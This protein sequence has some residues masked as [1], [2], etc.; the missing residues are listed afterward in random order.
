M[1]VGTTRKTV[2][3]T[4]PFL[5][6]GIAEVQEAGSYIVETSEELLQD[7]SFPA[8]QRIATLIFLPARPSGAS[9]DRVVRIDL[10][11]LGA[12]EKRDASIAAL[13]AR[14]CEGQH[15]PTTKTI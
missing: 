13:K 10:A 8:C 3:F 7:L 14:A 15:R 5:L 6:S 4:W 11:E 9:V 12:A 2:T 1:T